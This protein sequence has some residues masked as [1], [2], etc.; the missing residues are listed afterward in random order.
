[1]KI[2]VQIKYLLLFLFLRMMLH[3][4]RLLVSRLLVIWWPIIRVLN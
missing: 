3:I 4:I 2:Q 1:M